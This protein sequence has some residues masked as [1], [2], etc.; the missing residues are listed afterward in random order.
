M[1]YLSGFMTVSEFQYPGQ[2][3]RLSNSSTKNKGFK[4]NGT[5]VN[6]KMVAEIYTETIEKEN[7]SE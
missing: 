4:S 6:V 1:D 5:I 2:M 3:A 7:N